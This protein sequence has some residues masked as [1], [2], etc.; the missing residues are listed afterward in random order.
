[1]ECKHEEEHANCIACRPISNVQ[2][3]RMRPKWS[4]G[5]YRMRRF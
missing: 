4:D 3:G 2:H 5:K 1:M